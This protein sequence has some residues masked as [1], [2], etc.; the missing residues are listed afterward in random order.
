MGAMLN[1]QPRRTVRS[2]RSSSIIAQAIAVLAKYGGSWWQSGPEYS[3]TGSDGTGAAGDGS[4]VGYGVDRC[5]TLGPE[6]IADVE[7]STGNNPVEWTTSGTNASNTV[8][9]SPGFVTFNTSDTTNIS[10]N[11]ANA[12]VIGAAYE[13]EIVV[14]DQS[15]GIVPGIFTGSADITFGSGVGT[16]RVVFVANNTTLVI[17]RIG[18]GV[19]SFTI[20]RVSVKEIIGRPLTQ[21]TTGFKPKLKRV[22]KR[23]G[24]ELV[25]NG[26]FASATG[27]SAGTNWAISGGVATHGASGVN[28]LTQT[29]GTT[30]GKTYAVAWQISAV[31]SVGGGLSARI[32]TGG[33]GSVLGGVYSAVGSYVDLLT[34]TVD[35]T[36]F[37][38]ITRGAVGDWV[39][40]VDNISVREVLEWTWAWVF[41]GVDD[42]LATAS[43]PAITGE[44]FGI[45]LQHIDVNPFENLFAK[46]V[47]SPAA[48]WLLFADKAQSR[49]T[50]S[51]QGFTGATVASTTSATVI[52]ARAAPT[53][54][55][56]RKNGSQVVAP[57]GT[58]T[59]ASAPVQIGGF[60]GNYSRPSVM[61]AFYAPAA[62]PDAE[63]LIIERAMAQLAGVT[64]L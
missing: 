10:M 4:D 40:S 47:A 26:D 39:G 52:S 17:K 23:L 31:T 53:A 27:W 38:L 43:Q 28:T 33:A 64:I 29:I 9:F 20:D 19:G 37:Q 8:A 63:L 55:A 51:I 7:L 57:V 35:Q 41:D 62:I 3:F 25:T 12:L 30:A 2:R 56:F 22:P 58:Y 1:G 18:G 14:T 36:G 54:L 50:L 44:T 16:K 46:R 45:A 5:A 42:L 59:P 6:R 15:G 48:G 24:A 13:A 21:A 60:A 11:K 32:G 61:A 34:P 49:E